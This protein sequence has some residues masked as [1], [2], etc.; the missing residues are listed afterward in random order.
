[1]QD[2]LILGII[3]FCRILNQVLEIATFVDM[4]CETAIVIVKNCT[5]DYEIDMLHM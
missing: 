1:L 5:Q 3:W 2:V 4:L